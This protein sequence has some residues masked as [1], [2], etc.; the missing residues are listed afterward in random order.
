MSGSR[1]IPVVALISLPILFAVGV[2]SRAPERPS[3]RNRPTQTPSPAPLLPA[4]Q[5]KIAVSRSQP[6]PPPLP[7]SEKER[8]LALR[9][10]S[11]RHQDGSGPDEAS[12]AVLLRNLV[13][14]PSPKVRASAALSLVNALTPSH[15]TRE[16]LLAAV[17][18]DSSDEVRA[19][20]IHCLQRVTPEDDSLDQKIVDLFP[21]LPVRAQGA[22]LHVL[23]R[24]G[25]ESSIPFLQ[26]AI[27]TTDDP[28]IRAA[29]AEAL[30]AF[31][32]PDPATLSGCVTFDKPEGASR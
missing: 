32:P 25:H 6:V 19:A 24:R 27:R 14:D 9:R 7:E 10:M 20:A 26:E 5:Q 8:A 3:T 28:Q 21:T 22:A 23:A 16:P 18:R 11:S 4:A 1:R 17:G 2:L 15:E 13:D 12:R 31:S 30:A 29:V